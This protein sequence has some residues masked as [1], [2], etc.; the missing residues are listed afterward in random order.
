MIRLQEI[1]LLV[2]MVFIL[3]YA[4]IGNPDDAVWS[5]LYFVVNYLTLLW[6]FHGHKNKI[7]RLTG[8][9][10]SISILLFIAAK[11][12]FE[13]KIERYYT[14][15]PFAICLIG[16]VKLELRN[17]SLVRKANKR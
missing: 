15:I 14:S 7:I 9:S 10:L 6:L 12:F 5:G 16:L 4:T 17:A 13:L 3:V 11:Y 2:F 8:I 1:P